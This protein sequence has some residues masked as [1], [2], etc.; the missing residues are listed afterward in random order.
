MLRSLKELEHYTVNATDGDVGTVVTFLFDDEHWVIRYLV[1]DTNGLTNQPQV[2]VSPAFFSEVDWLTQR[3]RILLRKDDVQKSPSVAEVAGSEPYMSVVAADS[4]HNVP[5][6]RSNELADIHLR[7]A[8]EVRGY[9]VQASDDS[10]GHIDDFIVEDDIWDVRYLVVDTSNWWF[11]KKVLVAPQWAKR[12][13]WEQKNVYVDMSR[14][15]IKDSPEYDPSVTVNRDYEIR[16]YDHYREHGY[17]G[18][19]RQRPMQQSG[20]DLASQS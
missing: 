10:I 13:S 12:I 11:G 1:V 20:S 19:E 4:G 8:K 5:P 9:D 3:F 6:L 7:S 15:T 14:Q 18:E 16:L 17:W 2:L